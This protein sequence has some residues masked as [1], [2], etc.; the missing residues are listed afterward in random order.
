MFLKT[1]TCKYQPT[2]RSSCNYHRKPQLTVFRRSRMVQVNII[3]DRLGMSCIAADGSERL[4][5]AASGG[6]ELLGGIL[7]KG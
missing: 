6:V 3:E 2:E 7:M 4:L 5:W 1:P